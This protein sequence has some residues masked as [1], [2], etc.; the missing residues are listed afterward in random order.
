MEVSMDEWLTSDITF[1][2]SFVFLVLVTVSG[3]FRLHRYVG[4]R[5]FEGELRFALIIFGL[6]FLFLGALISKPAFHGSWEGW[7]SMQR[8]LLFA[9]LLFCF[10]GLVGILAFAGGR[11]HKLHN[12]IK[13][14]RSSKST[15]K[16]A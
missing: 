8:R 6:W 9:T 3:V 11:V 7:G 12:K 2:F 13:R 1:P 10:F 5:S 4:M 14:I 15:S 16:A